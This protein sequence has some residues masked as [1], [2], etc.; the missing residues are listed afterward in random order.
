MVDQPRDSAR[1]NTAGGAIRPTSQFEV[2]WKD[3]LSR[4]MSN[5]EAE[6][7]RAVQAAHREASDAI[8]GVESQGLDLLTLLDQRRSESEA[9]ERETA[10]MVAQAE[11]RAAQLI[12]DAEEKHRAAEAEHA[13]VQERVAQ[14]QAS[15]DA[16]DE[17]LRQN[18]EDAEREAAEAVA[19]A[20]RRAESIIARAESQADEIVNE[21]RAEVSARRGRPGSDRPGAVLLP[22][23]AV[24]ACATCRPASAHC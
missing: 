5:L 12:A 2:E 21:A 9:V 11:Q 16:A 23:V 15:I 7:E 6:L 14:I 10:A 3:G 13:A 1:S 17:E 8:K 22:R 4:L 18:R 20:R 19:A 24:G